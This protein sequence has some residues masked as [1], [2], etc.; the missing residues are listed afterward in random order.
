M[1]KGLQKQKV[2]FNELGFSVKIN[3][4][5]GDSL[6]DLLGHPDECK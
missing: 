3:S 2:M 6:V 5:S 4:F 1:I